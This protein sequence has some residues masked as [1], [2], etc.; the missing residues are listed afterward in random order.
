[1]PSHQLLREPLR[2]VPIRLRFLRAVNAIETNLDLF[3]G[4]M[5]KILNPADEIQG[6]SAARFPETDLN[7]VLWKRGSR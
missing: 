6:N 3:L 1:M 2:L 7:Q 4:R 5:V